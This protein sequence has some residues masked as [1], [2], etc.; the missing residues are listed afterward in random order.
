MKLSVLVC[1][2]ALLASSVAA[3]VTFVHSSPRGEK[4]KQVLQQRE[5]QAADSASKERW[6]ATRAIIFD[7]STKQ[8][9]KPT[10]SET[11]EMVK[12]LRSLLA[13]G[14]K[15]Q[16]R[17]RANGTRQG[18][19]EGRFQNVVVARATEEGAVETLCV[20]SFDEAAEFLGLK[21]QAVEPGE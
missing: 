10:D 2:T 11:A 6:V 18:S 21:P 14:E 9:R 8:L 19:A 5:T 7:S 15:V 3:E 4:A 12:S 13:R 17:V 1:S 20:E 16:P